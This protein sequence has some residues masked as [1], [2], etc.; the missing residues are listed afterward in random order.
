MK[1]VFSK[2]FDKHYK[3]RVKRNKI[4]ESRF[5]ERFKLF[6]ENPHNP[7]LGLHKLK[8]EKNPFYSFSITGDIRTIISIEDDTVI[9][10]DIGTHNQVY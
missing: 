4:L 5:I 7:V 3:K 9:F 2:L 1:I 8:G 6:V 10:H